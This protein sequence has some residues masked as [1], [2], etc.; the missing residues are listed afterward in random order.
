[1][2]LVYITLL[3]LLFRSFGM[4]LVIGIPLISEYDSYSASDKGGVGKIPVISVE[5][6]TDV[7][8]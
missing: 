7:V 5:D 2:L 8:S 3:I 4:S 6:S 1:M